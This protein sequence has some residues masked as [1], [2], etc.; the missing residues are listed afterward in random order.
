[1]LEINS[2][3]YFKWQQKRLRDTP[4]QVLGGDVPEYR[5]EQSE[6]LTKYADTNIKRSR[7]INCP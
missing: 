6:R 7:I 1:M 2:G 5:Y 4:S 3:R